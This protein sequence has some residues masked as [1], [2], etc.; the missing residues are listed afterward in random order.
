[1]ILSV[2]GIIIG[3]VAIG[4]YFWLKKDQQMSNILH[5]GDL[6]AAKHAYVTLQEEFSHYQ[7]KIDRELTKLY[8]EL[9]VKSNSAERRMDKMD[10][11]LPSIIRNVIGHIEFAQ[12]LDKNNK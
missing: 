5:E 1:M 6:E 11:S 9:E 10:K 12:P 2:I 8:K 4:L 7:V 3:L